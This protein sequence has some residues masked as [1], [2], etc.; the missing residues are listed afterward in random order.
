MF[1]FH[2]S[3]F[4]YQ[5]TAKGSWRLRFSSAVYI[6][7]SATVS[8]STSVSNCSTYPAHARRNVLKDRR[9]TKAALPTALLHAVRCCKLRE[10]ALRA[11]LVRHEQVDMPVV[12]LLMDRQ[13]AA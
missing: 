10:R 4:L 7:I 6:S 8:S 1:C 2:L 11:V 3:E 12:S 9:V 5:R 13:C